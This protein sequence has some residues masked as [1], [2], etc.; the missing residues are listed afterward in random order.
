MQAALTLDGPFL[1]WHNLADCCRG[2]GWDIREVQQRDYQQRGESIPG[3]Y[4]EMNMERG[5]G[6]LTVSSG[7][8]PRRREIASWTKRWRRSTANSGKRA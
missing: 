3:G 8:C 7:F 5:T 4:R 6:P 1:G 2:Q